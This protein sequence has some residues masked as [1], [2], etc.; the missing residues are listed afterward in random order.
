MD[1]R[2]FSAADVLTAVQTIN[3]HVKDLQRAKIAVSYATIL[4]PVWEILLSERLDDFVR[5]NTRTTGVISDKHS[6]PNINFFAGFPRLLATIKSCLKVVGSP[7][8]LIWGGVLG[9]CTRSCV[10]P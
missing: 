3:H 1:K 6:R 10:Q 7:T 2:D 9:V 8:K 4:S 5:N